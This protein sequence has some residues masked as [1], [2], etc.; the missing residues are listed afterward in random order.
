MLNNK[1]VSSAR[2]IY[3]HHPLFQDCISIWCPIGWLKYL[4]KVVQRIESHNANCS[5]N[6][7]IYFSQV[8]IKFKRLTIY[9]QGNGDEDNQGEWATSAENNN[10][11]EFIREVCDE[12]AQHCTICGKKLFKIVLD[13][14]VQK[15]CW[16]HMPQKKVINGKS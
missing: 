7:Q 12:A 6:S 5:K 16:D 2:D 1:D 13:S 4:D 11:R 10:I 3:R 9:I 14:K 15:V 8:K